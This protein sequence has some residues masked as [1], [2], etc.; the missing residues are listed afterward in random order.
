MI[1]GELVRMSGY[2]VGFFFIL[3]FATCLAMPWAKITN[4]IVKKPICTKHKPLAYL[5]LITGLIHM[6]LAIMFEFGF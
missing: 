3:N 1:N 5:T 4:K 2:L 6:I